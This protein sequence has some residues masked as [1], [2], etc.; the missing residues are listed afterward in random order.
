M[1]WETGE[2]GVVGEVRHPLLA[3][4]EAMDAYPDLIEVGHSLTPSQVCTTI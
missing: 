2:A 3:T 4:E 1:T